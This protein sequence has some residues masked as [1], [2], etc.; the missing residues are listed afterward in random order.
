MNLQRDG[1]T[2]RLFEGRQ[3]CN[4]NDLFH[5]FCIVAFSSENGCVQKK[6]Q[7][8]LVTKSAATLWIEIAPFLLNEGS[9]CFSNNFNFGSQ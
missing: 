6:P 1:R 4:I 7:M 2:P 3:L 9:F 5:V 8:R